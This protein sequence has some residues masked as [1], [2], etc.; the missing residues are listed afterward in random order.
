MLKNRTIIAFFILSLV[1]V[2]VVAGI[3]SLILIVFLPASITENL[4]R[5]KVFGLTPGLF[6]I[7]AVAVAAYFIYLTG[8][9]FHISSAF[10]LYIYLSLLV[11]LFL[12]TSKGFTGNPD[13]SYP[14]W[15]YV[16]SAVTALYLIVILGEQPITLITQPRFDEVLIKHGTLI[17]SISQYG[18][19]AV[20]PYVLNPDLAGVP[21]AY[22]Y[23]YQTLCSAIADVG[24][25]SA[26]NAH[27]IISAV[28]FVGFFL[29]IFDYAKSLPIHKTLIP[30]TLL[31]ILFGSGISVVGNIIQQM[32]SN[33]G[34]LTADTI[35]MGQ[36]WSS[37]YGL[38]INPIYRAFL[39]GIQHILPAALVLWLALI[40][41][42]EGI[43]S[44]FKVQTSLL[45]IA[46]LPVLSPFVSL[47]GIPAALLILIICL[48]EHYRNINYKFLDKT[49]IWFAITSAVYLLLSIPAL[50]YLFNGGKN[51]GS[52]HFG[53]ASY[54]PLWFSSVPVIGGVL[55]I[56]A[57]LVIPLFPA[58]FFIFIKPV[59]FNSYIKTYWPLLICAF[60]GFLVHFT[61]YSNNP[62]NDAGFR[63]VY[64]SLI[65]VYLL[66]GVNLSLVCSGRTFFYKPL[67]LGAAALLTI[68]SL[69]PM[70]Y[71]YFYVRVADRT[72]SNANNI[73]VVDVNT[74]LLPLYRYMQK[75]LPKEAVIQG[76]PFVRLSAQFYFSGHRALVAE[77]LHSEIL[78]SGSAAKSNMLTLERLLAD[79][80]PCTLSRGLK[81]TGIYAIVVSKPPMTEGFPVD[82]N[83]IADSGCFTK[84]FRSENY[85]LFAPI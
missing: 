14:A 39:N 78:Y 21:L 24:V 44:F 77:K 3:T 45:C 32:V 5:K 20:N 37:V 36:S 29:L 8:V 56:I 66:S 11:S 18:L 47:S 68:V 83:K 81:N 35:L 61:V 19:P 62:V 41:K 85:F 23:S 6:I 53:M 43:G 76:N 60:T 58:V 65:S 16:V 31:F 79:K 51:S 70:F 46:L 22:Y 38:H 69:A 54:G 4:T 55:N 1:R 2:P 28:I 9:I 59:N 67:F 63:S 84:I 17:R 73:Y 72:V 57:F 10:S 50:N 40:V 27:G 13:F 74:D 48:S 12:A 33:E 25:V 64:L 82:Y 42:M 26:L 80:N 7:P 71:Y 34:K 49:T 75:H 52:L 30:F 15:V